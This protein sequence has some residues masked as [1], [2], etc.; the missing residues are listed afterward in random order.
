[1]ESDCS[2][3]AVIGLGTPEFG[4]D[5]CRSRLTGADSCLY[6]CL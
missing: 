4:P 2:R 5:G 3:L 1:M 6:E